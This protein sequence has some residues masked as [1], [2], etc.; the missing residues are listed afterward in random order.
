MVKCSVKKQP[1]RHL[2]SDLD[3]RYLFK[4]GKLSGLK[5]KLEIRKSIA[6]NDEGELVDP[7]D[8]ILMFIAGQHSITQGKFEDIVGEFFYPNQVPEAVVLSLAQMDQIIQ[9]VSNNKILFQYNEWDRTSNDIDIS[10]SQAIDVFYSRYLFMGIK[11][12]Y[13]NQIKE[14]HFYR[15]IDNQNFTVAIVAVGN[16]NNNVLYLGELSELFP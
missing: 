5:G 2:I 8:P 9:A 3:K 11:L 16:D 7:S 10:P 12:L 15:A 13:P 14:F 4:D 1:L 6:V